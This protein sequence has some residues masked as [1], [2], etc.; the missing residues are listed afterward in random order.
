MLAILLSLCL[1]GCD[2]TQTSNELEVETVDY[3]QYEFTDVV[4]TRTT[5]HDVESLIFGSGGKFTYYCACGNPVNDSDLCEGYIYNDDKKEIAL[6][7]MEESEESISLIKI[8]HWD[9]RSIK[10]EFDGEI[11]EFSKEK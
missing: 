9:E 7:Y 3:S 4:W 11:R 5:E 1:L 8:L 6:K 10:L 2:G